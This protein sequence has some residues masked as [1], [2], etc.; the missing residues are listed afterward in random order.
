M[1]NRTAINHFAYYAKLLNIQSHFNH[2]NNNNNKSKSNNCSMNSVSQKKRSL[3][4]LRFPQSLLRVTFLNQPNQANSCQ[5][6][7]ATNEPANTHPLTPTTIDRCHFNQC[8][9]IKQSLLI[10]SAYTPPPKNTA[11]TVKQYCHLQKN[12]TQLSLGTTHWCVGRMRE[13]EWEREGVS[14]HK[15]VEVLRRGGRA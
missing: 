15:S 7:K 6:S 4:L 5:V 13:R 11:T 10:S 3:K 8:H 12:L 1:H 9:L 14:N 2:S